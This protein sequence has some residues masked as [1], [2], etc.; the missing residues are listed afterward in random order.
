[1]TGEVYFEVAKNGAKPFKVNVK[2]R[3]MTVGVL[4]TYFNIN[5]YNDE[6]VIKTTLLEGAVKIV[7]KGK[8]R[9]LKPNQQAI[10]RQA[11]NDKNEITVL[12]DADAE[13]VVA[14]KHEY[15]HLRKMKWK[16]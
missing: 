11:Q 10:L 15:F 16:Q 1:V 14:W 8:A 9:F 12:D 7:A 5:A 13:D 3:G 2:D 4:G 6:A